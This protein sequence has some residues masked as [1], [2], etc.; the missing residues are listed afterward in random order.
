MIKKYLR[1]YLL[2]RKHPTAIIQTDRISASA[3][4]G[5]HVQFREFVSLGNDVQVG[6][7][8]YINEY[9]DISSGVIGKFCS[10][11]RMCSIGVDN[12]PIDWISTSPK[13]YTLLNMVGGEGYNDDKPAPIIGNDVWIG[14]NVVIL[15]GVV[16]GDGAVIGAGSIV[17]KDI[18]PYAIAVGAPAKVIKYRFDEKVIE[19]LKAL[20]WWDKNEMSLLEMSDLIKRRQ[21]FHENW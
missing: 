8:T 7:Y 21:Q 3:V 15:R 14:C 11:A 19:K 18:P 2:Q 1:K 4:L 16:I 9:T 12:H 6:D 5:K 10:I 13:L 20:K 17:T